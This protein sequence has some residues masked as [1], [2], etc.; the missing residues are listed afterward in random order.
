M[1]KA[2]ELRSREVRQ[3]VQGQANGMTADLL[4]Q[5]AALV[6]LPKSQHLSHSFSSAFSNAQVLL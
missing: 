6:L 2:R 4:A 3:L 1:F 5:R